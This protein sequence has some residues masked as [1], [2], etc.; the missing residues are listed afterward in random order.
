MCVCVCVVCVW[1]VCVHT[2]AYLQIVLKVFFQCILEMNQCWP[3]I[4]KTL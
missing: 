2:I 3:V 1:C 4:V